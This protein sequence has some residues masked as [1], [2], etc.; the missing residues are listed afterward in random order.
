MSLFQ[1]KDFKGGYPLHF[2]NNIFKLF[3]F[4]HLLMVYHSP[5]LLFRTLST[6]AMFLFLTSRDVPSVW[7]APGPLSH[8]LIATEFSE[9]K[10]NSFP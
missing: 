10:S 1:F 2:K 5:H 7:K 3:I 4:W 9:L 6:L 8:P